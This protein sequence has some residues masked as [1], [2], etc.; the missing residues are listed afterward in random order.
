MSLKVKDICCRMG[1][2]EILDRVSL[3]V[4]DG[5]FVG[6]VGPNGCGKSTLLKNIY[7]SLRPERKAVFVNGSD[8][9]DLSHKELAGEMAVMAQ[10]NNME[11]DFEVED[12]VMFGRYAHKRFL[13]GDSP[14]DR[15]DCRK[16]LETVG[17]TGYEHR[18]YLSLSGGEKQRVL[19]ARVLMQES[20]MIVLDEPTNHLDVSYQY[21]IMDILTGQNVT[22]FS[23]IHDLNLA[24]LYCHR[25]IFMYNGQ[26][27][28]YGTPEEVLTQENIKKYFGINSLIGV[29]PI[30][31][32]LQITYMPSW[33]TADSPEEKSAVKLG[34][35]SC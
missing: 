14:R 33:I 19:L 17:L 26:I 21:Q 2:R 29:N 32:K 13:E 31:N 12:M 1:G 30:T 3:E 25:I 9:L 22:V 16:Y 20:R 4:R 18:S 5:E 34:G 11:F 28:D 23:S 24:A 6:L 27:V 15:E 7:R 10:E 35:T 8:V